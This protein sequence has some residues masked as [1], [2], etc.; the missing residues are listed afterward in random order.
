MNF[1]YDKSVN[2]LANSWRLQVIQNESTEK[3]NMTLGKR[4]FSGGGEGGGDFF[5]ISAGID[6]KVGYWST[7]IFRGGTPM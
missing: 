2:I 5:Q 3:K 4:P 7:F 1:E 6:L